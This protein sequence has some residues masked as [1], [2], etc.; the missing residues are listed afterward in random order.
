MSNIIIL[1]VA[2]ICELYSWR[3]RGALSWRER[4]FTNDQAESDQGPLR[5]FDPRV[6]KKV[7]I[8][9]KFESF[10]LFD[11]APLTPDFLYYW[12]T[13]IKIEKTWK[14][15]REED[16]ERVK[17]TNSKRKKNPKLADITLWRYRRNLKR[18]WWYLCYEEDI[19]PF[20]GD[21]TNW[22]EIRFRKL[23]GWSRLG[24]PTKGNIE[25][26]LLI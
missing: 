10:P 23:F 1:E 13:Q 11:S 8:T 24:M 16:A 21:I 14:R 19:A 18:H 15:K 25:S 22:R 26:N 2:L 5:E 4:F 17:N 9:G 12:K 3:W 20:R 7:I 6:R